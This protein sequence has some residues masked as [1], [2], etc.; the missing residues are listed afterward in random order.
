[1]IFSTTGL[2]NLLMG[3]RMAREEERTE[4][5]GLGELGNKKGA[6]KKGR[7]KVASV[8]REKRRKHSLGASCRK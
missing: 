4:P 2:K 7:V 8:L 3:V 5:R 6:S 1:M